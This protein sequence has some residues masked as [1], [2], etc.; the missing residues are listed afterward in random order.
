VSAEV[1]GV[2]WAFSL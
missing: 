1:R 2:S